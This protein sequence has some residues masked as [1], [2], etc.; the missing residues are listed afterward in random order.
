MPE[1]SEKKYMCP[2]CGAALTEDDILDGVGVRRFDEVYCYKHFRKKFPDECEEHPG[3][4]AGAK[5]SACGRP[6]C[7]DCTVELVDRKF[8]RT[9]KLARVHELRTGRPAPGDYIREFDY[10]PRSS[11]PTWILVFS[12]LGF[13]ICSVLG[14][15]SIIMYIVFRGKVARNEVQPSTMATVGFVLSVI[16]MALLFI[17]IVAAIATAGM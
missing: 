16:Q 17:L 14:I 15:V 2:E 8:C 11:L 6:I 9:C 3:K 12:I 4:P 13:V 10:R 1:E 5:C 7:E